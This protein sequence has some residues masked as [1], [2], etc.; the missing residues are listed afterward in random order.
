MYAGLAFV[1]CNQSGQNSKSG[2]SMFFEILLIKQEY[3]I[4]WTKQYENLKTMW[5][6]F[7][8][9]SNSTHRLS[10]KGKLLYDAQRF[11]VLRVSAEAYKGRRNKN[12]QFNQM[13]VLETISSGTT[14]TSTVSPFWMVVYWQLENCTQGATWL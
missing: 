13:T 11:Q 3:N 6:V 10:W 8:H 2:M 14:F 12:S 7:D 5:Q 4:M 1:K 9:I